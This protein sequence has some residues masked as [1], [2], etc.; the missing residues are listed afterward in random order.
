MHAGSESASLKF[1]KNIT[2]TSPLFP[3]FAYKH[4]LYI[5]LTFSPPQKMKRIL[6]FLAF[7]AI[8][9][10]SSLFAQTQIDFRSAGNGLWSDSQIWEKNESGVWLKPVEGIYPGEQHNRDVNVT[11]GNGSTITIGKDEVV[12]INS[13]RINGGRVVV[14]GTLIIGPVTNDPIAPDNISAIDS[15]IQ[16][17]AN[18]LT[19]DAPQLLQNVPNP[20]APQFG[21]ETTI[22]FYL[23]KQ[24]SK[25][26]VTIFDQLSHIIR[27]V[28]DEQ[29]PASGWHTVKVRLDG[30]Q[31]GTYPL[32]LE[33]PNTI[34]RRM[35]MVL[36]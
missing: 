9:A 11:V 12:N 8:T 28:F 14:E 36:R 25:V 31:S 32:V 5:S 6:I 19:G 3:A 27:N 35:I 20:L 26:R 21:Y 10:S 30:I 23:D 13:L 16:T 18:P 4:P 33:L 34:L 29:N 2:G 17:P 1:S 22:K 15:V 7:T 24:Y